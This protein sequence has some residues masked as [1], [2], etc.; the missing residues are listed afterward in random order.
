WPLSDVVAWTGWICALCVLAYRSQ[1]RRYVVLL[2]VA[3]AFALYGGF[4]EAYALALYAIGAFLV[5]G[6][7]AV[8]ARRRSVALFGIARIGGGVAAGVALAAPLLLP[9]AQ[10]LA[11]SAR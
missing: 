1:R 6:G 11:I 10:L 5:L 9:G 4:P 3:V 2:A 7:L 8:L